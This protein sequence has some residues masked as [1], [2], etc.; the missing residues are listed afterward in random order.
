MLKYESSPC[1]RGEVVFIP[2][3]CSRSDRVSL[4]VRDRKFKS[5]SRQVQQLSIK[6]G[7]YFDILFHL[8][9]I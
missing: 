4:I 7:L 9:D 1:V 6:Q 5:L 3:L 8:L 2:G